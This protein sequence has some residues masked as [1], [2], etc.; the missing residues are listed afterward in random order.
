MTPY[1]EMCQKASELQRQL[2]EAQ[3]ERDLLVKTLQYPEHKAAFENLHLRREIERMKPV[4]EAC[5]QH[6]IDNTLVD[7]DGS[8]Y[9]DCNCAICQEYRDYEAKENK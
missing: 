5:K 4:V 6:Y 1:L 3:A 2:A 9:Q 8:D 7:D